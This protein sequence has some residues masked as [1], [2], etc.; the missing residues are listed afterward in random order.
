MTNFGNI[1]Y[2]V[3]LKENLLSISQFYNEG[4]KMTSQKRHIYLLKKTSET[5]TLFSDFHIKIW[6]KSFQI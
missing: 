4:Y 1:L 5:I 3:S 6:I 2:V